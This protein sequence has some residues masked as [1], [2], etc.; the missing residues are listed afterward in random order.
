MQERPGCVPSTGEID[1]R[2]TY[3]RPGCGNLRGD[4]PRN[5]AWEIRGARTYAGD[6]PVLAGE[7]G[8]A[9]NLTGDCPRTLRWSNLHLPQAPF[10]PQ[11]LLHF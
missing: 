2:G 1:A 9:V 6:A 5:S 11:Q 3:G 10:L 7:T 8:G 4:A